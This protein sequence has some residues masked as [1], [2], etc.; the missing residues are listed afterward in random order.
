MGIDVVMTHIHVI[1]WWQRVRLAP[2]TDVPWHN[3]RERCDEL[4]CQQRGEM[5]AEWLAQYGAIEWEDVDGSI[6]L[7]FPSREH[8]VAWCLAWS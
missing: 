5:W 7:D 3:M 6:R 8:Y 1:S 2:E 4:P